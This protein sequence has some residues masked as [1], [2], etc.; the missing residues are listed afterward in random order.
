MI[1]FEMKKRRINYNVLV[2]I[3]LIMLMF[4]NAVTYK[5]LLSKNSEWKTTGGENNSSTIADALAE[6]VYYDGDSLFVKQ[7]VKH[8]SRSGKLLENIDFDKLLSDDKVVLLLSPNCC[9]TCATGEIIKLLDLA[10][11]IGRK[12]LI[13]VADFA[14]HTQSSWTMIFD[15]E[16]YYETDVEHLGLKGSPTRETPVVML[17]NNGHIKTSYI[18]GK[19][20]CDFVDGFHDY[21][22]ES[23]KGE[24]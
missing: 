14:M 9:S 3:S 18:V 12:N 7:K 11:K 1:L 21:I 22:V 13:F 24:K 5:M 19:Q 8:Y 10:K 20:T 23:F 16:G 4:T 15:K 17:T 2:V 6:H